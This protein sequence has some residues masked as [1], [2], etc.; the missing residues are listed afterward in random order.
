MNITENLPKPYDDEWLFVEEYL[1]DYFVRD[2]VLWLD[3]LSRFMHGEEIIEEDQQWIE[4]DFASDKTLVSQEIEK[5]EARF[6]REAYAGY[7]NAR[8]SDKPLF[9]ETG[10]VLFTFELPDFDE[11]KMGLLNTGYDIRWLMGFLKKKSRLKHV[12]PQNW[13]QS[14]EPNTDARL[15]LA[16]VLAVM[17]LASLGYYASPA[18]SE[19]DRLETVFR[20]LA[21]INPLNAQHPASDYRETACTTL[22]ALFMPPMRTED[23]PYYASQPCEA[24][25]QR[26]WE[27]ELK[28]IPADRIE[29]FLL[30]HA[31]VFSSG[32]K[33]KKGD[34]GYVYA[35]DGKYYIDI[36]FQIRFR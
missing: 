33:A 27:T 34:F 4:N 21:A 28:A 2:D 7:L 22:L 13:P 32:R 14:I 20:T 35:R 9:G 17:L 3:I 18:H 6:L 24:E 19:D 31:F 11:E 29:D 30:A 10:Q 25:A 16:E 23:N 36:N 8:T 15:P 26:R 5:I 1:P 12:A